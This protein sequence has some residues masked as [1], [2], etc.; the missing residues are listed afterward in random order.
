M[1]ENV[2][3]VWIERQCGP[4]ACRLSLALL[5][6]VYWCGLSS[7]MVLSLHEVVIAGPKVGYQGRV[8][9]VGIPCSR[10]VDCTCCK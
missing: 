10:C 4:T 9:L 5:L 6:R 1:G 8:V 3:D 7:W 2:D